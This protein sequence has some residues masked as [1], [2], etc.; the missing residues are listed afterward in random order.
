MG[1]VLEDYDRSKC[2]E[3]YSDSSC[4]TIRSD[5]VRMREQ[6]FSDDTT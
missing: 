3:F 1:Q 2:Q 5:T 6:T 4:V